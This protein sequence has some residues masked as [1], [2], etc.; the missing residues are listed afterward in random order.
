MQSKT[1]KDYG[2]V[3]QWL[4]DRDVD[5]GLPVTEVDAVPGLDA[6]PWW[7]G[8]L[9]EGL[10]VGGDEGPGGVP[11]GDGR[12]IGGSGGQADG[13]PGGPGLA[14]APAPAPTPAKF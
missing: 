14:P 1:A 8:S 13:V 3:S 11:G 5:A 6:D 9:G 7:M 2:S 4:D 12:N 10:E